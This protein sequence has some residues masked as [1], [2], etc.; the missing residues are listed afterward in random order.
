M[1]IFTVEEAD[2]LVLVIRPKLERLKFVYER[3]ADLRDHAKAAASASGSGGGMVGGMSYVKMLYEIGKL[4][5]EIGE[6]GVEL[7]DYSRGLVDFP[8]L[9]SGRVILLCWQLG[10]SNEIEWWQETEAGF[11]GRQRL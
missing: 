4:T 7:K 1:K 9:R 3:V 2:R 5:T 6:L 11:A 10:D 8:S